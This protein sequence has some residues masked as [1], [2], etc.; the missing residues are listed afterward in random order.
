MTKTNCEECMYYIF[1]DFY[2]Y[3]C[4]AELDEDEMYRFIEN[5]TANCPYWQPRDEYKIV[6]KQN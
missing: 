4:D 1:D 6:R 3:I 2:G 5:K